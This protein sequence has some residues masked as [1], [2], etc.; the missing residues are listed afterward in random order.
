VSEETVAALADT[1]G[2][3]LPPERRAA[4]LELLETL[5]RGGGGATADE[6]AG[7]EPAT[8]FDPQWPS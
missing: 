4:V 6:L 3:P 2:L 8:E 5:V 1:V 7:L